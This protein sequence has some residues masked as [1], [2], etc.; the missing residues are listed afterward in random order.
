MPKESRRFISRSR[1]QKL[2]L[3]NMLQ[4]FGPNWVLPSWVDAVL[5]TAKPGLAEPISFSA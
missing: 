4:G 2:L 1:T 5:E 3:E